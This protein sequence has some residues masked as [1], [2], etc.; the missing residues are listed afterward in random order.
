MTRPTFPWIHPALAACLWAVAFGLLSLFWAAG[1]ELGLSTLARSIQDAA[2]DG[3]PDMWR[4]TAVT[5]VLKIGAGLLA[6]WTLRPVGPRRL[7]LV[8]LSV[9]W[10]CAIL[11]ALYGVLGLIEKL[12]MG[13]GVLD[14]PDGLGDDVVWWYVLLWE[15]VWILGGVLFFMTAW[16]FGRALRVSPT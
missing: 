12:L 13:L 10:G 4:T 15:P 6:L 3:D 16:L 11:F 9:L 1:G 14:V 8:A 2:R 7:R 5:G